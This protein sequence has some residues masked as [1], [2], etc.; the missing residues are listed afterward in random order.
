[1][2]RAQARPSWRAWQ[3]ALAAVLACALLFF[4]TVYRHSSAFSPATAAR[5][6]ALSTDHTD[7]RTLFDSDFGPLAILADA[8]VPATVVDGSSEAAALPRVAPERPLALIVT[9]FRRPPPS[10]QI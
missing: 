9:P 3:T 7:S 1:M 6:H 10:D 4:T 8:P 5:I 2:L